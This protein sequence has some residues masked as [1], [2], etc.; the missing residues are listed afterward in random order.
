MH[1]LPHLQSQC[2]SHY[3]EA[4]PGSV[5]ISFRWISRPQPPPNLGRAT[6]C[7]RAVERNGELPFSCRIPVHYDRSKPPT[8]HV[9]TRCGTFMLTHRTQLNPGYGPIRA[10]CTSLSNPSQT[11]LAV[12][13]QV[14][15]QRQ[16]A[17]S[18]RARTVPSSQWPQHWSTES[19]TQ[20]V[21][22]PFRM[23]PGQA[24]GTGLF[25][26]RDETLLNEREWPC[27][28]LLQAAGRGPLKLNRLPFYLGTYSHRI[29]KEE[30]LL[31]FSTTKLTYSAQRQ[32]Q[33]LSLKFELTE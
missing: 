25:P 10:L 12:C 8:W 29:Y 33:K 31:K 5:P 19:D 22:Q 3:L 14:C 2:F 30:S 4:A 15:L 16:A 1:H 26:E 18:F 9:R 13:G 6:A 28:I 21:W 24:R 7:P 27:H 17:S 32:N 20:W 23:S 11:L